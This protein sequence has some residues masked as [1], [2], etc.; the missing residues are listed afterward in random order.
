MSYQVLRMGVIVG[1][2][3]LLAGWGCSK[4]PTRVK[5]PG[6]DASETGPLALKEYDANGDG[7]IDA[8]ELNK[9]PALKASIKNLDDNK[10][11]KVSGEEIVARVE[12]WQEQKVGRM[13]LRVRVTRRGQPLAGAMVKFVPEKFLGDEVQPAE[14][15]TDENGYAL[16]NAPPDPDHPNLPG[17][18]CGL[19]RVEITKQGDRIPAMYNT[20]T[21]FGQEVSNDAAGIQEGIRYD[22]K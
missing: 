17:M 21:I 12:N 1:C 20:Q 8:T 2:V 7:V 18:H 19:Y 4:G 15:V 5:P 11:G 14:G 22:L 9:A 10:D 3:G 13:G 16:L 6:I